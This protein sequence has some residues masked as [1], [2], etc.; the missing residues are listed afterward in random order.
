MKLKHEV[1]SECS[2]N[3]A[4]LMCTEKECGYLCY[5]MYHCDNLCYDYS[6]GHICKHIHRVHSMRLHLQKDSCSGI[7]DHCTETSISGSDL[8][9]SSEAES[10]NDP[11]EFAESIRTKTGNIKVMQYSILYKTS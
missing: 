2:S 1:F 5:H 8:E 9:L 11:L 4:E 7:S 3:S 10:Y 6:N